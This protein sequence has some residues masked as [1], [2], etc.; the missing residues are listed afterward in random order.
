MATQVQGYNNTT[1]VNQ[2]PEENATFY[3]TAMLD[4]LL[5]DL[6]Y[7]KYGEEKDIPKK[8]G[9]SAQWR[10]LN[11][12]A[13][14][15]TAI[16]EGVT[17]D[18]VNLDITSVSATVQEYGNWTK[19]SEFLDLVGID[20]ILTETSELMGENAAESMDTIVRDII[21]AGP[22]VVYAGGVLDQ[23]DLD[24][25]TGKI[26]RKDI[27]RVRT[28]LKRNKVKPVKLPD[29]SMGYLWFIHPD[30]AADL[31]Q[32]EEW[33]SQ[34]TY[35]SIDNRRNGELGKMDGIYFL[36]SVNNAIEVNANDDNVHL[37]III[38]KGAYGVPD[39]EGSSSP[40]I[41]VHG[42]GSAGTAD[43]LNQFNTVAWKSTF[44]AVRLQE[45]AIVRYECLASDV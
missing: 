24:P 19:I 37:N 1:G 27:L 32:T 45:L 25:V 30:V 20:P 44:T 22:N 40:D 18:G 21:V 13:V 41:I 9:A 36:E 12:L 28:I 16:T 15:N 8:H 35:V 10:R 7:M 14:V 39:V 2:L 34:N 26:N 6:F 4:R 3:K 42:R 33:K 17:P 29:G 5:P 38:G 31:M 11:S 43:P 23:D